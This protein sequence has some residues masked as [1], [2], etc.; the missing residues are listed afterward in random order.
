MTKFKHNF[1]CP[2]CFN[3][4]PIQ[5]IQFRCEGTCPEIEDDDLN[6]YYGTNVKNAK[7]ITTTI[8]KIKLTEKIL[9]NKI[10][11]KRVFSPSFT[12]PRSK[13]F[14]NLFFYSEYVKKQKRAKCNK[15]NKESGIIVCPNCHNSLTFDILKGK[16][17]TIALVGTQQSGKSTYI[18]VLIDQLRNEQKGDDKIETKIGY[19]ISF[20][21]KDR[22]SPQRYND[23]FYLPLFH[24]NKLIS[25]TKSIVIEEDGTGNPEVVLGNSR[26][27]LLNFLNP[28]NN[29]EQTFVFYD[30]A[31]EDLENTQ[32]QEIVKNYIKM[33][34]AVIFL[35]DPG[36]FLGVCTE[37]PK[38][39][40]LTTTDFR[41]PIDVLTLVIDCLHQRYREKIDLPFVFAFSKL[42]EFDSTLGTYPVLM[43][44]AKSLHKDKYDKNHGDDINESVKQYMQAIR[45]FPILSC[46]DSD[47]EEQSIH[48]SAFSALGHPPSGDSIV[49]EIKPYRMEDAVYYILW[50]FN[51]IEKS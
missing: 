37:D 24:K 9:N 45:A 25:K 44:S 27:I 16:I 22:K 18:G 48:F 40:D 14:E 50:K 46:I 28:K 41:S 30:A 1:T 34:N 38:T 21:P 15:C 23:D 4:E 17:K 39:K 29:E 26:P 47:F 7:H 43:R 20:L 33:A 35:L 13:Y 6:K 49:H 51:M 19:K 10:I 5:H 8:E 11:A 12:L 2:Y 3:Q 31:G 36:R 32:V 42:D